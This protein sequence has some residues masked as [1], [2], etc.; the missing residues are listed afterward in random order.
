MEG[1]TDL[2]FTEDVGKRFEAYGWH[3]GVSDGND[4]GAISRALEEAKARDDRPSLIKVKTI[5][6]Y[7]SP[8]ADT[9]GVHG[10]RSAPMVRRKLTNSS[11]G[12]KLT[13]LPC[14]PICL[15]GSATKSKLANTKMSGRKPIKFGSKISPSWLRN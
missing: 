4:C 1:S 14:R 3:V 11:T 6:G 5:I 10:A 8:K 7:S 15:I 2:A 12:M 9:A 13:P